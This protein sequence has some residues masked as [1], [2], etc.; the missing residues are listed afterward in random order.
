MPR[1][2]MITLALILSAT[3]TGAFAQSGTPQEQAACRHDATR[4]C[5][6]VL[7][8]ESRVSACLEAHKDQ[9]SRRCREVLRS[10]GL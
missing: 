1:I 10:H 8:D 9:L 3:A 5:R 4:F 7:K 2:A 6:A